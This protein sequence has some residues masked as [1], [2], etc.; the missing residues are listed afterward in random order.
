[1]WIFL[2]D[3][4]DHLFDSIASY[5]VQNI[6]KV[7]KYPNKRDRVGRG[8][9]TPDI[10]GPTTALRTQ[11]QQ[12]TTPRYARK[13]ESFGLENP[14]SLSRMS[15]AQDPICKTCQARDIPCEYRDF[16]RHRRRK[17]EYHDPRD[18]GPTRPR[19]VSPAIGPV[20]PRRS[21]SVMQNFPNSVSATHMASPSCQVQLYYGP[22]SH[23]ALMQHIYRGLIPRHPE[24]SGGV[25]EASA[26]L[27]LFSFRRIFFGTPDTNEPSKTVPGDMSA[28]FLPYELAK[29]FLSRFLTSLY[30]MMPHRSKEYLESCLE[31]LYNP[32]L[33]N[34][35]DTLT[36]AIVL[37]SAATGS[38]GTEYFAWGDI[39]FDRVKSSL[40]SFDDVVNL[41]TV[42]I[43]VLMISFRT[44]LGIPLLTNGYANFQNEQGRPNSAFLHLGTAARKALAAGLHK[45]VPHDNIETADTI[46]E[47]RVTFWSLYAFETWFCFH[48]GRPSSLSLNDVAI[49]YAQN[50]FNRLLVQL[51]KAISRS[52]NEIYRQRH[53]SLLHMWRVAR[54]IASDLQSLEATAQEVLG[55]GLDIN[56]RDPSLGQKGFITSD[57]GPSEIPSWLNEAC[58][59]ALAAARKTIHHLSEASRISDLVR[60]LRY[61]GYFMGSSAFTLIYGFLH[62]SAAAPAH[63]PWVYAALQSLTSM[64]AGDPITSSIAAIQTTLR[65]INPSY[66]WVPSSDAAGTFQSH[67]GGAMS[68]YQ[69]PDVMNDTSFMAAPP[70][71]GNILQPEGPETGGSNGSG[72]DLLDFT[73]SNMGWNLD[74]STMDLEA[75]F[76]VYQPVEAS[77]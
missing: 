52:T 34:Q 67:S 3:R 26:G 30:H 73:Q 70:S 60:Q 63:L 49:E 13:F 31:H 48:A 41:Q 28:M 27:D 47:R 62:D 24:P 57:N 29:L 9:V 75:F 53:N 74:F 17:H 15:Q 6:Q 23:F 11:L 61:H 25:D 2:C 12:F 59:H 36:Q 54:S 20:S 5:P 66:E 40:T 46:E 16:I 44:R 56:T 51:C 35:L 8:P 43:S 69:I 68:A 14:E 76:S 50:P 65:N 55:F 10:D 39:L 32:N 72:E 19:Q 45:D 4:H 33:Q 64:R 37:L 71:K 21:S 18:E 42:Q 1:M 22:T 7:Q 38:L 58:S 77:Q